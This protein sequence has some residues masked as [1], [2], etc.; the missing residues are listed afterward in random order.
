MHCRVLFDIRRVRQFRF[1]RVRLLLLQLRML[2]RPTPSWLCLNAVMDAAGPHPLRPVRSPSTPTLITHLQ[3]QR[4]RRRRSP[5]SQ[6]PA[7][8]AFFPEETSFSRLNPTMCNHD[9]NICLRTQ[10][11]LWV[12]V[13][14]VH[15]YA[16]FLP[17]PCS[18]VVFSRLFMYQLSAESWNCY[19]LS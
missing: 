7:V 12:D 4:E 6:E 10:D 2:S 1:Q 16:H 3:L 18:S 17:F 5:P 11:A 14:Y 19:Q 8:W 15:V 9:N 13:D